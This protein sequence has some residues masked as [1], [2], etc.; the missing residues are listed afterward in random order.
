MA[1]TDAHDPYIDGS[2]ETREEF[3]ANDFR[4]TRAL[5]SLLISAKAI[6]ADDVAA[7]D[8]AARLHTLRHLLKQV[9]HDV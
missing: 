1:T 5:D 9:G 7:A 3:T 8:I 6:R 4:I 2:E